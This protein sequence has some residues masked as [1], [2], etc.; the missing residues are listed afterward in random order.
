MLAA[1]LAEIGLPFLVRTVERALGGLENPIA[2][3]A[4]NALKGDREQCIERRR[5]GLLAEARPCEFERGLGPL[6]SANYPGQ[7]LQDHAGIIS[8][9][10]AGPAASA[11]G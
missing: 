8:A 4:A 7:S 2:Q 6:A 11:P 5:V 1:L 3:S 10:R 9:S